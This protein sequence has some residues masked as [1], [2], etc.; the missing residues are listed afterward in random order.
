MKHIVL[1]TLLRR[2]CA[3][4]TDTNQS[5]RRQEYGNKKTFVPWDQWIK[6]SQEQKDKLIAERKKEQMN[7]NNG[8]PRTSYPPR[9][10]N[11]HG[12][13]ELV[14]I[15]D[16]IDYTMLNHDGS[17]DD[18]DDDNGNTADGDGLLAYMAGRSSSTGDIR[19][20]MATKTKIPQKGKSST[21]MLNNLGCPQRST[22]I[23]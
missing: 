5:G 23:R 6:L 22:W 19:K 4:A 8:K 21:G 11:A 16:I 2:L 1:T 20:L 17:V 12:V 14:D 3:N 15:D 9:Q 13:D 18:D 10:A 7:S